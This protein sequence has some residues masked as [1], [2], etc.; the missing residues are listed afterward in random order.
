MHSTG[1][2]DGLQAGDLCGGGGELESM[3]GGDVSHALLLDCGAVGAQDQLLGRRGEVGKACDGQVLVVEVGVVAESLV[4]LGDRSARV[5]VFNGMGAPGAHLLDH[6]QDPR[7]R[8]VVSVRANAQIHLV[9]VGIAAEG[10]HQ[11]EERVFWR[12]GN[13]I[14]AEGGG[15]HWGELRGYLGE[16]GVRGGVRGGGGTRSRSSR[17]AGL[18][19]R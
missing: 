8:V 9:G 12:L 5:G 7:L 2:G 14:G 13:H 11:A 19:R 17:V 1:A 6:G 16:A 10:G 15:S 4:G 18:C 3:H